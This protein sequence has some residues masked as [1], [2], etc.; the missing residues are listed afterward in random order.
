MC[1]HGMC[2]KCL[3]HGS[4]LTAVFTTGANHKMDDDG[5]MISIYNE[6]QQELKARTETL[7][8]NQKQVCYFL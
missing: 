2:F 7:E 4:F 3:R 1:L 5:I 6:T 8:E